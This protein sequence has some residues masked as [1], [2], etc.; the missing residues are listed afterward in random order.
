M[1]KVPKAYMEKP[2]LKTPLNTN[3]MVTSF[4]YLFK[5]T[6][7]VGIQINYWIYYMLGLVC[8]HLFEYMNLCLLILDLID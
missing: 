2:L 1:S 6:Y 4:F 7:V 8:L 3:Q 5:F